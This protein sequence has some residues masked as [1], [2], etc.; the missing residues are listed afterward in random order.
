MKATFLAAL[1]ATF[2][3][4]VWSSIGSTSTAV[5][6]AILFD[7]SLLACLMVF[8]RDQV[9]LLRRAVAA[10]LLLTILGRFL[11]GSS[12]WVTVCHAAAGGCWLL[13]LRVPT[14]LI[15]L[16]GDP[17]FPG[18]IK[19]MAGLPFLLWPMLV[20][21]LLAPEMPDGWGRNG[22]GAV[23]FALLGAASASRI[24]RVGPASLA[25]AMV[26]MVFWGVGWTFTLLGS[27][28]YGH[29]AWPAVG[30]AASL[31]AEAILVAAFLVEDG[32]RISPE[33][34]AFAEALGS[35]SDPV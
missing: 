31:L 16:R 29:A 6:F 34:L 15:L 21:F 27:A 22:W 4:A 25:Y 1:A 14:P 2:L 33:A 28:A 18:S 26:A 23:V 12:S 8:A 30:F 17:P 24:G 10:A 20:L 32:P 13:A 3:G 5:W 11:P 35:D 19:S 7:L 9:P